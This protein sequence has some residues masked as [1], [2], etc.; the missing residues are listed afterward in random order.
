MTIEVDSFRKL[1]LYK[2]AI[3]FTQ[4]V[5]DWTEQN[6]NEIGW[7]ECLL[8]RRMATEIPRS[9]ALA[10]TEINVKNKYKKLN[11]SK[12]AFQKLMPMLR[13]YEMGESEKRIVMLSLEL[14][15][16]FNGFFG[17]LNR[18]KNASRG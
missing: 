4:L 14:V 18:K 5:L 1:N 15:K 17:M 13:R 16:L 11:R 8:I 12:E 7:K 10:A 6:Q 9:I 3:R 2:Q